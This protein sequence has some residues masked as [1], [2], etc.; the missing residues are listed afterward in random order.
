L[1][2]VRGGKRLSEEYEMSGGSRFEP[3]TCFGEGG[4]GGGEDELFISTGGAVS[5]SPTFDKP[6][7]IEKTIEDAR[8]IAQHVKNKD[9][10]ENVCRN[11]IFTLISDMGICE[12]LLVLN[13]IGQDY[14]LFTENPDIFYKSMPKVIELYSDYQ[15]QK[16]IN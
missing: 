11:L 3:V 16:D 4:L 14:L 15:K 13:V 8:F 10:F 12:C 5:N 9:K 2:D 7:T 6:I 1:S